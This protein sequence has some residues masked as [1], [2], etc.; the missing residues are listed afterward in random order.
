MKIYHIAAVDLTEHSGR[1][2]GQKILQLFPDQISVIRGNQGQ[3]NI[4]AFYIKEIFYRKKK[5]PS[6]FGNRNPRLFPAFC[7][8]SRQRPAEA[9]MFQGFCEK[10]EGVQLLA[11]HSQVPVAGEKKYRKIPVQLAKS[12][13]SFH[14][15]YAGHFNIQK[16]AEKAVGIYGCGTKEILP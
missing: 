11:L 10:A 7:F 9:F 15:V 6:V 2:L 16:N 1:Q 8:Q 4:L 5:I 13:G 14:T 3:V 12:S